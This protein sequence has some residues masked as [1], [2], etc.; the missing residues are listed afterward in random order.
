MIRELRGPWGVPLLLLNLLSAWLTYAALVTE[1]QGP[2]DES[3]LTAIEATCFLTVVAGT[4][5]LLLSS[6]AVLRRSLTRWW[7]APPTASL[8]LGI[9][10][11]VYITQSYPLLPGR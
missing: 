1:P 4:V 5:T 9:V 11:W 10:R 6:V 3:A 2:W 7:L 8:F